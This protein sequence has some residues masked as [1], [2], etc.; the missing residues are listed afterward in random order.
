MNRRTVRISLERLQSEGWLRAEPRRAQFGRKAFTYFPALPPNLIGAVMDAPIRRGN[1]A[2]RVHQSERR[3]TSAQPIGAVVAG[4]GALSKDIGVAS[5]HQKSLTEISL[6][7]A[8]AAAT[9]PSD[10]ALSDS[11]KLRNRARLLALTNDA[12]AIAAKMNLSEVEVLALL[13][14]SNG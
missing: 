9:E 5:V 1:G 4:I 7:S 8:N 12:T 11:N 13:G 2:A 6:N 14:D 3:Q 10:T